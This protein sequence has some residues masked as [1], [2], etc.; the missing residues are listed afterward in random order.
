MR[1]IK[2]QLHKTVVQCV[3]ELG[4]KLPKFVNKLVNAGFRQT[5]VEKPFVGE[6]NNLALPEVIYDICIQQKNMIFELTGKSFVETF[7]GRLFL[8]YSF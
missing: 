1:R 5:E 8:T 3:D 7:A 4:N 6:S 2:S